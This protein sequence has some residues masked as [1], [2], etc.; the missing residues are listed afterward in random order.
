MRLQVLLPT[1]VLVDEE[2]DGVVAEGTHGA[3]VLLPRHVD[4]VAELVQGLLIAR[5]AEEDEGPVLAV[6]GG[7]LVKC[8]QRV[9]V[10]TP[11]AIRGR[12]VGELRRRAEEAFRARDERERL[13]RAALGKLGADL[14]RRFLELEEAVR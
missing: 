11:E 1:E 9:L 8:G 4:T 12:E 2:V 10:S 7:T 6:D 13:A 14:V 3:F 5:S